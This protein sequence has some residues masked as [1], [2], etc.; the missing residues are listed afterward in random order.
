MK[1]RV[2]SG[3]FLRIVN[4]LA[5][6]W[7]FANNYEYS[8]GGRLWILWEKSLSFSVLKGCDQALSVV[9]DVVGEKVVVTAVY[10]SN[11]SQ[12]RRGLWEH[13]RYLEVDIGSAS[14]LIGGD[15]NTFIS[16]EDSSDFD[17]LGLYSTSDMVEFN[18][19]L[20]DLEIHDHPFTGPLFTW[21]NKQESNLLARKLDRVLINS[22]WLIEFPD[23]AVEFKAQGPSDHC[24]G[25]VW[26]QKSAQVNKPKPFKFFNCWTANEDFLRVVKDS[27]QGHC[28]GDPILILFT[29]LECLKPLL[30]NLNRSSFSDIVGRVVAKRA[31][32]EAIQ[33][34]NLDQEGELNTKFFHQRVELNKKRNIIK[35]IKDD[36]GIYHET[37]EDMAA[38]LEIFFK[39]L[40]GT[41]DPIVKRCP[42][43]WL[44]SVLNYSL[45]IGAE[46]ILVRVITDAEIKDALFR[47]GEN[48]SLGPDGYASW[49]FKITWDIV[50]N[51]FIGVVRCF[52][53]SSSLLPAFN[54]TSIVLV[55]KSPNACMPKEFRPISCCSMIYK[56]ITR[57]LVTR[58]AL[59]F[60]GM[61]SPNQ[62]AFVKGSNIADNTLLAQEVVRG[63]SRKNLSPRCTIKIDLQKAFDSICWDFLMNVLEALGLL[64]VF[65][66]WIKACI[67]TPR[68]SISLNGSLVGRQLILPKGV[69]RDVE[70][71]CMRL[72]WRGSDTSAKGARVSWNQVYSPQS[73]GG[74]GLRKLADW[75]KAC[76]LIW[77][78]SKLIKLREEA[79][80]LFRH[81]ASLS[82]VNGRLPTKDIL[83][84]FGIVVNNNL[85]VLCGV[86]QESRNHLFLECPFAS[87]IWC[88]VL[89]DCEL[90]HQVLGY[91]D[92][93][94]RWMVLHFKGKSLLVHILKLAWTGCAAFF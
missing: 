53:Q 14:W 83:G 12:T 58:L 11:N 44:K 57:I 21:S 29:K 37:F 85:C 24:L 2:R 3:N 65:C 75:S 74:L 66:G 13:L 47:Q 62:S 49:F 19:C 51:D 68:F 26:T 93:E 70:K 30:K 69:I 45:P 88:V 8:E 87:E 60:P 34:H 35:V 18:D 78:L 17:V 90:K 67:T 80:R 76:C 59:F 77:I 82:Q 16:A 91:W 15:F 36:R 38:E 61:I 73:E 41:A 7:D 55:P 50:S 86:G 48:K 22:Q 23:S 9:G 31:E 40:I 20:M 4:S 33:I 52:F 71:L 72:F 56:T 10:G 54:A 39:S 25:T 79:G 92:D 46:D 1:T 64:E 28:V 43:D 84:R 94:I 81:L 6:D 27:W 63:Y 42:T 32:L 5:V 89:L